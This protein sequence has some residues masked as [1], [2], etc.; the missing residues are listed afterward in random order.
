MFSFFKKLALGSKIGV[1]FPSGCLDPS[2]VDIITNGLKTLGYI[3]ILADNAYSQYGYL[4]G[5]D[6]ERANALMRLWKDPT[7]SLIWCA[8]GGYGA[9]R[10]LDLLD[11]ELI[12]DHPKILIGM[13]DITALHSGFSTKV[14]F[15]TFLG[16]NLSLL[17]TQGDKSR[18]AKMLEDTLSY[19]RSFRDRASLE[20][21]TWIR[22]GQSRAPLIGGNLCVLTSLIGTAWEPEFNNKILLLEDVNEAPYRIDRMLFQ[23]ENSGAL[24]S[25]KGVILSSFENCHPSSLPSLKLEDIFN[26]YFGSKPYPVLRGFPS[27]HLCYQKTLP[28]GQNFHISAEKSFVDF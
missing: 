6:A 16:P 7:I 5:T 18:N 9:C 12:K 15:P 17:F 10:I 23:L 21:S 19:L 25:L 20:S 22:A 11:F 4:A 1:A 8:K 26:Q 2:H 28:L 3:P 13:S 27:G 14:A 24:E